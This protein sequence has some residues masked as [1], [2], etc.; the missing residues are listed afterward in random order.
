MRSLFF[1][2]LLL[3]VSGLSV[4]QGL[5]SLVVDNNPRLTAEQSNW[6]NTK[7]KPMN[8][9]FDNKFIGYVQLLSGAFYGIGKLTLP[10]TK[11]DFFKINMDK[12]IYSLYVLDSGQKRKTNGYDAIIVVASKKIKGKM[13]RLEREHVIAETWNRYPQIPA[14]AGIDNNPVLNKPNAHFFNE[15]YKYDNRL[16]TSYD[17]TGK[18]I[19]IFDTQ[20]SFD[21]IQQKSIPEYVS[22]IKRQLDEW[23][24]CMTEFTY[25]L[26]EEQKKESGGYDVIIQYRCKMDVPLSALI[27]QLK[28][29]NQL[30]H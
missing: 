2:F 15:I 28:K 19:A 29:D 4:A 7:L 9:N 23:G 24:Y 10:L 20:C 1:A 25:I 6:L 22:R 16:M 8:F 18:K 14:D 5:D 27:K 11:K 26:T 30:S 21:K 13:R 3:I 12:C 17:F